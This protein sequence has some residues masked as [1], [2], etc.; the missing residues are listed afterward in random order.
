MPTLDGIQ[1]LAYV[2]GMRT[3]ATG[4]AAVL[5]IPLAATGW[6]P[7]RVIVYNSAGNQTSA[8]IGIFTGPGATG[9]TLRASFALASLTD[10][11]GVAAIAGA[12]TVLAQPTICYIN[13]DTAS[14]VAGT[15]VDV[16]IFG[17]ALP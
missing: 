15:A 3:D 2:K 10:P 17:H 12:M 8:R 5:A 6:V 7:L 14:G 13:V 1:P 4:D 16:A 11:T 9:T